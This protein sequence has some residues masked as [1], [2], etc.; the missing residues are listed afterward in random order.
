MTLSKLRHDIRN[1]LNSIKLSSALLARQRH[2]AQSE[3]PGGPEGERQAWVELACLDGVDGL[4]GHIEGV[5]QLG[6]RPV[7]LCAQHLEPIF[8]R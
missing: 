4:P 7:A 3:E 5:G 6:L 2:D 8:H 1:Y